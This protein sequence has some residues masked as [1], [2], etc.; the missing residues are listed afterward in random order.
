MGRELCVTYSKIGKIAYR[1]NSPPHTH[2][3]EFK[4]TP[5]NPLGEGKKIKDMIIDHFFIRVDDSP[6][7]ARESSLV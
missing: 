5:G 4:E 2:G 1:E 6:Q 7:Q 3:N